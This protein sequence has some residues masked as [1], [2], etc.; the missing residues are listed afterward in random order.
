MVILAISHVWET[1]KFS[2]AHKRPHPPKK[3]KLKKKKINIARNRTSK[4]NHT[5]Y[6][7]FHKK[8]NTITQDEPPQPPLPPALFA[9]FFQARKKTVSQSHS[10]AQITQTRENFPTENTRTENTRGKSPSQHRAPN[11]TPAK[12]SAPAPPRSLP[13]P[14]VPVFFLRKK[15]HQPASHTA[16]KT[17]GPRPSRETKKDHHHN[18]RRGT[19]SQ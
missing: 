1:L 16:E 17:P 14:I 19:P 4:H 13:N 9:F 2:S 5:Y 11:Q 10:H 15:K 7:A 12:P 6:H 18:P 8:D 3:K